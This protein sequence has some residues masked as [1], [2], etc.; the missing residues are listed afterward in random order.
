V[1]INLIDITLI[2]YIIPIGFESFPT[3]KKKHDYN[4]CCKSVKVGRGHKTHA[5]KKFKDLP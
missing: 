1:N 3:K 4:E 2:N 5:G